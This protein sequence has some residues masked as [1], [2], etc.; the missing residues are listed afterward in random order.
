VIFYVLDGLIEIETESVSSFIFDGQIGKGK[1]NSLMRTIQVTTP[2]GWMS[3]ETGY[4]G[5]LFQVKSAMT[6]DLSN[7]QRGENEE[8]CIVREGDIG[9]YAVPELKNE[10][11]EKWWGIDR[12]RMGN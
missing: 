1:E 8:Q 12:P 6:S 7:F 4:R 3:C 9:L 11:A 2:R 5:I 10:K